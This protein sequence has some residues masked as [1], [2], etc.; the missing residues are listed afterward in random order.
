MGATAG[1]F[2][3][4]SIDLCRTVI[5]IELMVGCDALDHHRPLRSGDGVE[6]MYEKI[7][8]VVPVRDCDR[9]PAIDIKSIEQLLI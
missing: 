8:E 5:A 2:L 3:R 7:R 6:A 9:S 1:L 4:Q